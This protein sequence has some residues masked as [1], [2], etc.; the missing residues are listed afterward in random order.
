MTVTVTVADLKRLGACLA[1][2]ARFRERFGE[3]V[4]LDW[5]PAVQLEV[6][7]GPLGKYLGWA[8]RQGLLSLWSLRGADLSDA[9]LSGVDLSGVDLGGANLSD[10]NLRDTNL[11]GANLRGA[12]LRGAD[13]SGARR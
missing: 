4:T 1:G 8:C 13:L 3:E 2:V 9:D 5:T 11:S 12:N 10:A 7:R 6:L